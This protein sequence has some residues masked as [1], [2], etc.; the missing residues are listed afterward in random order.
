MYKRIIYVLS[1]ALVEASMTCQAHQKS[2]YADDKGTYNG[3]RGTR[4]RSDPDNILASILWQ[5]GRLVYKMC[6]VHPHEHTSICQ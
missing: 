3:D 2:V 1:F 6:K 5:L 4:P